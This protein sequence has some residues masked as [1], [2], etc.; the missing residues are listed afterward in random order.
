MSQQFA[1]DPMFRVAQMFATPTPQQCVYAGM[2]QDYSEDF[3]AD[4]EL[5][6]ETKAGQACVKRLL[7][8]ERGHYGC[9]TADTEVL[10]S[11]GWAKWPDVKQTDKLAAVNIQNGAIE[12][13]IPSALQV[14]E[15]KES[16]KIYR[17]ESQ[18]L[19]IA[20]TLDHRMIV[21]RRRRDGWS[22]WYAASAA[23]IAGK[24]VRYMLAGELVDRKIPTDCPSGIDLL[25]L[26]E[27]AGF[28]F[29]DGCRSSN[30]NPGSLRF[31]LR[32]YR[33]ISYLENLGFAV[34]SMADDRYTIRDLNVA[35][36]I[37]R[38]FSHGFGKKI[39][40]FVLHL[41]SALFYAFA[42]GLR[43]S[44]G[45]TMGA[46]WSYDSKEKEAID[47]LQAVFHL[48]GQSASISL[49]NPNE[50][51]GHENHAPCW[52]LHVSSREPVARAEANQSGRTR[53]SEYLSSYN[54]QVYCATVSTG[55]LLVR[56]N[57]KPMVSGNCLEHPQV[58]FNAGW[59]P[60]S[61]M[62]QARTHRIGIS[63][64]VQSGRYTSQR[65]IDVQLG[66]RKVEEVFYLR[67]VGFYADRKG[68]KYEYSNDDRIIDLARCYDAAA[69]YAHQ[70]RQGKSE[71]HARSMIPFDIRQHFVVSFSMRA[72]MHF[73]D[74][75]SKL[76]A[77]WEIQQLSDLLFPHF[78]LWAPEIAA[79]YEKSRLH[80]ARLAP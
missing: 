45:V 39:P 28:F 36:W 76:D 51:P 17:F 13:E 77:Q 16:D 8:G 65:I 35:A 69:H 14:F 47:M 15:F 23:S 41:P 12:F 54:G 78:Q 29:G 53:A 10:T 68:A 80:K 24:A 46:G 56:R 9:Y 42:E 67:P 43:N 37:H 49:N 61:V 30:K 6:D 25:N 34:E 7:S 27:L 48:N 18:K 60:H 79:W 57:N 72:L 2:H 21:S 63:F 1:K 55:A 4:Q 58:T 5:P 26:F 66:A 70:I 33:K 74:L 19:D 22:K 11:N 44:D 20:V 62:Q 52:R 38:H 71:E 50:G 31:K 59:F 3:V 73:L 64:D 75:R 32:K 40:S